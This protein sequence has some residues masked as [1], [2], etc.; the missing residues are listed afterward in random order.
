MLLT[1]KLKDAA[2]KILWSK[3]AHTYEFVRKSIATTNSQKILF[4]ILMEKNQ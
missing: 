3:V 1:D 4:E 2:Q